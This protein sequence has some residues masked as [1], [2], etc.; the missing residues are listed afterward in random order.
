ME[1]I[2]PH[3]KDEI[4]NQAS[5][6]RAMGFVQLLARVFIGTDGNERQA[7]ERFARKRHMESAE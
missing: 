5:E 3:D 1:H 7:V 6:S 2:H 4:V